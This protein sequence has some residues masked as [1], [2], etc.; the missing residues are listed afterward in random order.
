MSAIDLLDKSLKVSDKP[1]TYSIKK[2]SIEQIIGSVKLLLEGKI[3]Q[4]ALFYPRKNIVYH[5]YRDKKGKYYVIDT[6]R[7]RPEKQE[8]RPEEI[9]IQQVINRYGLPYEV[10]LFK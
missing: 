1:E 10:L 3:S 8:V 6:S 2:P 5:I 4:V 7:K 9:D